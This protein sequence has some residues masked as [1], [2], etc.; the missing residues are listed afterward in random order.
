M[1]ERQKNLKKLIEKDIVELIDTAVD[2]ILDAELYDETE[3]SQ[4]LQLN[5]FDSIHK[6]ELYYRS[7]D[8]DVS[9]FNKILHKQIQ[10]LITF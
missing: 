3:Y 1:N 7:N 9:D 6:L 2:S 8:F 4:L 10:K 5:L